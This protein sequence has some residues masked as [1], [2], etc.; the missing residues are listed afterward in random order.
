M[1]QSLKALE[2]LKTAWKDN[3]DLLKLI[4]VFADIINVLI[5][6]EQAGKDIKVPTV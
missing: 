4:D 3:K 2:E 5:A 6:K 1:E